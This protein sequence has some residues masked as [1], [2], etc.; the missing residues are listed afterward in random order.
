MSYE[1]I[2]FLFT[3]L[4]MVFSELPCEFNLF[5][6]SSSQ[7]EK[8][9]F[10]HL[11]L[12]YAQNQLISGDIL[13]VNNSSNLEYR[14]NVDVKTLFYA[15][16]N[17]TLSLPTSHAIDKNMNYRLSANLSCATIQALKRKS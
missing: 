7:S 1:V 4:Y 8:L 2:I 13:P 11:F 16:F 10:R 14:N 12:S 15:E 17:N 3:L 9:G 5:S 6:M